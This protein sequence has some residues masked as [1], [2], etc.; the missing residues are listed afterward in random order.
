MVACYILLFAHLEITKIQ[1]TARDHFEKIFIDHEIARQRLEARK[2]ELEN[3]ERELQNRQAQNKTERQKLHHE[4]I[5]VTFFFPFFFPL[6]ISKSGG[7]TLI[8]TR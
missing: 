7:L 6:W 1:K 8:K 3:L 2:N 5:M 4:K